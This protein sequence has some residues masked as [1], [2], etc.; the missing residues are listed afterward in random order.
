MS[1]CGQGPPDEFA[2]SAQELAACS[3][4]AGR[5]VPCTL[6]D[7]KVGCWQEGPMVLR[8]RFSFSRAF[9]GH[10]SHPQFEVQSQLHTARAYHIVSDMCINREAPQAAWPA[11]STS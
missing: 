1:S 11:F 9:V 4:A 2:P 5:S 7:V 3:G 8:S 10:A 6:C